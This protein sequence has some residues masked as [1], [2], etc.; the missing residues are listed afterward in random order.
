MNAQGFEP[1]HLF[2]ERRDAIDFLAAN[3]LLVLHPGMAV[4]G[5]VEPQLQ[6]CAV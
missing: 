5:I 4:A 6:V 2:S 3:G 1:P